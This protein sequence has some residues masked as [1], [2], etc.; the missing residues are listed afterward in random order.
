[1]TLWSV[2]VISLDIIT[3]CYHLNINLNYSCLWYFRIGYFPSL[4]LQ[5]KTVQPLP[6]I[7][8]KTI[9]RWILA[10]QNK[11]IQNFV[12]FINKIIQIICY[13]NAIK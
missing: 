3:T 4:I 10:L 7:H 5:W 6:S 2:S 12:M 9:F 11:G 8:G 1:M 13:Y